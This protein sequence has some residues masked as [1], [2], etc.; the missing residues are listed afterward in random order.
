MNRFTLAIIIAVV[1]LI[2]MAIGATILKQIIWWIVC[3]GVLS[4][5]IGMVVWSRR[6]SNGSTP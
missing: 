5:I 6:S 4:L 3:L 1:G 2:L